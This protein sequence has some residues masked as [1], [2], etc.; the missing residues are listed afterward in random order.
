MRA[1]S[2]RIVPCAVLM[3]AAL[4]GCGGGGSLSTAGATL[5]QRTQLSGIPQSAVT[6]GQTYSF[7]PTVSNASGGMTF[8][9]QNA[10]SWATFNS[11]TGTL[12][13]TPQAANAGT[14]GNIVISVNNGQT[15][16]SLP[17]FSIIVAPVGSASGSADISWTP[18]TTNVN[19]STLTDLAGYDIYYGTSPYSLSQRVQ[20]TN[21]GLS[22]YVVS[23]LTPGTW[24]FAV[25]AYTSAG[26]ESSLSNIA[27]KTIS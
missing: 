25:V 27:S 13:G 3:L 19:G 11:S 7:T 20:V 10:P 15:T 8:S 6:A 16:T 21:T 12:S 24:Y 9:I 4:A 17:A 5:T 2:I 1:V 22:D 18:P 26:I 23:G 14:Y